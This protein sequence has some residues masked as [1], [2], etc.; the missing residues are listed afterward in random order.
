MST[1]FLSSFASMLNQ[2]ENADA[3]KE[4][5]ALRSIQRMWES[6]FNICNFKPPPMSNSLFPRIKNSNS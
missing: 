5:E 6:F 4:E 2:F 3:M 1:S